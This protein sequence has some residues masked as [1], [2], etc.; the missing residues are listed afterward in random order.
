MMVGRLLS[1]R[2][3]PFLMHILIFGDVSCS[4]QMIDDDRCLTKGSLVMY[5]FVMEIPMIEKIQ[6]LL[7]CDFVILA[8]EGLVRLRPRTHGIDIFLQKK[9]PQ[10]TFISL[11]CGCCVDM[12]SYPVSDFV[13]STRVA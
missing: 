1:F 8:K 13:M 4:N 5:G 12:V 3:V 6:Y 9:S 11:I 7:P 2:V 10:Q